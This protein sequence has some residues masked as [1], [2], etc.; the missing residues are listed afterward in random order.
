MKRRKKREDTWLYHEGGE[1]LT[2]ALFEVKIK[3]D[4]GVLAQRDFVT[5]LDINEDDIDGEL[6]RMPS[7]YIFWSTLRAEQKLIVS[8]LEQ[9]IKRRRGFVV[10]SLLKTARAQSVKLRGADVKEM[11][12]ADD[13]LLELQAKKIQADRTLSKL[14]GIVDSLGVKAENLRTL[15]AN[16]RQEYRNS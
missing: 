15:A 13:K 8:K 1:D 7:I 16:R 4:N 11:I 2:K 10:E 5:D 14:Y 6:I 3:L 12:E 9:Q